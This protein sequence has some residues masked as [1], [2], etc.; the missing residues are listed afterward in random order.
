[1]KWQKYTWEDG[2]PITV[3]KLNHIEHGIDIME[4]S[5][6]VSKS[7][8]VKAKYD[9]E[10]EYEYLDIDADKL[11]QAIKSGVNVM[12]IPLKVTPYNEISP[13]SGF[14]DSTY[15][16]EYDSESEPDFHDYAASLSFID[17]IFVY[18]VAGGQPEY[19]KFYI[20]PKS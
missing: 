7:L 12:L 20:R 1:M 13:I 6:G 18:N 14:S 2:D 15:D 16:E 3:Q 8:M 9:P 17:K 11:I 19:P 4:S 5:G 10:T